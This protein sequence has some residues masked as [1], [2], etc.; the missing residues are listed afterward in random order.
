MEVDLQVCCLIGTSRAGT[1]RCEQLPYLLR[2]QLCG[3]GVRQGRGIDGLVVKDHEEVVV[4][5]IRSGT[6]LDRCVLER[7]CTGFIEGKPDPP[8]VTAGGFLCRHLDTG[9]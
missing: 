7:S 4:G 5:R 2:L 8:L 9:D 3:K 6:V 1:G